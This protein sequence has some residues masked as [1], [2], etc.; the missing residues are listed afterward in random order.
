MNCAALRLWIALL[1]VATGGAAFA[2][3]GAAQDFFFRR[4]QL[5]DEV[6]FPEAAGPTQAHLDRVDAFLADSQW[7]EAIQT[8][9]RV[10]AEHGDQLV[11][12][13]TIV[14][15]RDDPAL[16]GGSQRWLPL[17]QRCQEKLASLAFS[18]PEA[19]ALY[20][21]QV[22]PLAQRLLADGLARRD[23]E[24]LERVT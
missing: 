19:L 3:H 24:T 22:D 10:T 1:V 14:D 7:G 8:L 5:S 21:S 6:Q 18:A 23:V 11:P 9:Q 16:P 15:A 4:T 12:L 17:S 20:R 2:P 13:K